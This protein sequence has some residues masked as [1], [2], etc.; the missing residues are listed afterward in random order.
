[1]ILLNSL[2]GSEFYLNDDL[3]F[4]IEALPDT[5]ITLTDGKTVRVKESPEAIIDRIVEYRRKIYL[6][7]PEV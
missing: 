5:V 4:K 2:G 3:I 6:G 1:M 7:K